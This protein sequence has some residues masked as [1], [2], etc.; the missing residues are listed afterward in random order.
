MEMLLVRH[1]I[2]ADAAPRHPD[3]LRPLTTRGRRRMQRAVA[4]LLALDLRCDR[5]LHSP[6]K[7]AA[8]T[9]ELLVPL[10]CGPIVACDRLALPPDAALIEWLRKACR[11]DERLALVGHQPWM[12]ELLALLATASSAPGDGILVGKG[13]VAW[14][15]GECRPGGMQLRALF[16]PRVLRLLGGG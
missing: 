14:L 11:R 15:I 3:A 2:A 4:G 1:G 13:G 9:A 10:A 8:Q 7:R 6:W 5:V 12:G 16:P